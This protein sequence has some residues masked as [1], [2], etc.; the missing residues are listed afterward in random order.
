MISL[1]MFKSQSISHKIWTLVAI[2]SGLTVVVAVSGLLLIQRLE[3]ISLQSLEISM[4]ESHKAKLLALTEATKGQ[5]QE[6]LA[7]AQTQDEKIKVI[8]DSL[9]NTFFHTTPE[10]QK[11]TGY[12][13]VYGYDGLCVA[14]PPN[15]DRHGKNYWDLQDSKKTYIMQ[16]M[17]ATAKKG[18]GFYSYY[19]AKPGETETSEK[20][21]YIAPVGEGLDMFIGV[22]IYIDD[23]QKK[24][25]AI[26]GDMKQALMHFAI[27][28]AG[29]VLA[30]SIFIVTPFTLL[31]IR[32]SIVGPIRQISDTMEDIAQGEGDLTRRIDSKSNDELGK[33]AMGFNTF[34]QKIH[35]TIAQVA[36]SAGEVASAAT[37]IAAVSD[38][39][40]NGLSQQSSQVHQI[41][42]AIEEMNA[43]IV[44]VARKSIDV[45][46]H[47]EEDAKSAE[48]GGMIVNDTV[49]EMQSIKQTVTDTAASVE[50]LGKRGEQIGQIIAVIND[51][52]DQTNLLALNAAIEA[53]RA[54]EHGRGFAVVADEVRKLADRTTK[55]TDEIAQSIT[56]I[57]TE[58]K[59][60]VERMGKG[61]DQVSTGVERASE[62]G[63]SLR[64]IVSSSQSAVKMIQSIAAAAEE[65]S[66]ASTQVANN[67][68]SISNFTRQ[69]SEGA[70]QAAQASGQ[71]SAKAEQLQALVSQFKIDY[72]SVNH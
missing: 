51:I 26:A 58:T 18:G 50:E 39:M 23:V 1:N 62:A 67:I 36:K 47:A 43:S 15:P 37:E 30:Y 7:N 52:A 41:S 54:G 6:A 46:N 69:S 31:L 53:A 38:E 56:A 25:Q 70:S 21:S 68:E 49:T 66:T 14:M 63:E 8:R 4:V 27:I 42:S 28:A 24:K 45:A 65:Q 55:A 3:T 12:L 48:Q 34:A 71:L 22:G 10:E 32:R 59:D 72:E 5:M 33:L 2:L 57:Q 61:T 13:F 20:L 29:V 44:E 35:D 9:K 60:A 64:K 11:K 16:D 40:A 17:I 19:F